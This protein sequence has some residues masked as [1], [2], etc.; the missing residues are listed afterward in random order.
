MLFISIV[1]VCL[2]LSSLK[3]T[4]QAT[5]KSSAHEALFSGCQAHDATNNIALF[6]PAG[7]KREH[8]LNGLHKAAHKVWKEADDIVLMYLL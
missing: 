4:H 2:N 1:E 5:T 3:A 6:M 8:V 7:F